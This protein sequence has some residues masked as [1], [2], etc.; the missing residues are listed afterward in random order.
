[1][2][3]SLD[4]CSGDRGV[5]TCELSRQLSCSAMLGRGKDHG[6]AT[7]HFRNS[8]HFPSAKLVFI[9]SDRP[10]SSTQCT[11][12]QS[13]VLTELHAWGVLNLCPGVL[14]EI[15]EVPPSQGLKE[16]S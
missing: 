1:M 2:L 7:E 15:S 3:Q 14:P 10:C 9:L 4:P 6:N 5:L 13:L 8:A 11:Q 16:P 12:L